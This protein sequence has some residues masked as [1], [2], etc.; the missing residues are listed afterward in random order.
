M[1]RKGSLVLA[2]V[3]IAIVA[4]IVYLAVGW[5]VSALPE[6]GGV[7]TAVSMR[8]R[9]WYI[10]RGAA[11]VSA[12]PPPKDASAVSAG[13]GSYEMACAFCHGKGAS[14]PTNVGRAMYPR[15]ADLSAR[16]VQQMSDRELFWVVKNG[17][18][19]TGMPGFGNILSDDQI[20]QV[21]Y[22]VRTLRKPPS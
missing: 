15:A 14:G 12:K 9:D 8:A 2:F 3:T 5:N 19:L 13:E 1:H 16:D 10:R 21:T 17:L 22:Y 20:W 7:E 6:P 11:T 18:R 4:A